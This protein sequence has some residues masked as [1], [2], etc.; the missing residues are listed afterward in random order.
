MEECFGKAA[1]VIVVRLV[2][3]NYL[4]LFRQMAEVLLG[5]Q[6]MAL[7]CFKQWR[8]MGS[9]VGGRCCCKQIANGYLQ[10]GAEELK[11]SNGT[12][13]QRISNHLMGLSDAA[14]IGVFPLW[15]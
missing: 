1:I 13:L 15:H 4:A 11:L 5:K 10:T 6:D 2:R 12:D 9:L 14:M 3:S 7:S 8:V